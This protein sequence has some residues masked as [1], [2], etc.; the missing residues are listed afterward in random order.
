MPTGRILRIQKYDGKNDQFVRGIL[1]RSRGS[2]LS[3]STKLPVAPGDTVEFGA[4]DPS[5]VVPILSVQRKR[6]VGGYNQG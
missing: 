6:G 5:G 3:F 1:Q 2:A 4:P